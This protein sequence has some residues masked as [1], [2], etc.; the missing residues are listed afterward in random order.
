[1]RTIQGIEIEAL[2]EKQRLQLFSY[3]EEFQPYSKVED[4]VFL[5]VIWEAKLFCNRH[6]YPFRGSTSKERFDEMLID[7]SIKAIKDKYYFNGIKYAN[8]GLSKEQYLRVQRNNVCP[9][10]RMP[11][12][13]MVNKYDP[14]EKE[15]FMKVVRACRDFMRAKMSKDAEPEFYEKLKVVYDAMKM[16]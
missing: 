13:G 10:I 11:E 1:M 15:L 2:D 8:K 12:F 7:D 4:V 5:E 6:K 3:C 14:A 9:V 16:R